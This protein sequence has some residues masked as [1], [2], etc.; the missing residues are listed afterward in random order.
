VSASA[1]AAVPSADE[2]RAWLHDAVLI[3]RFEWAEAVR[4]KLLVVMVLLFVGAGA[5]GAWGF[6]ELLGRIEDNAASLTGAPRVRRPGG[7]LRR[8]RESSSYRDMLRVFTGSEEKATYFASIPPIVVFY[9]WASLVFTPW[10]I[11]FTSAETVATEVA[12]RSIRYT[13]LRTRRSAYAVG[14]ALGQAGILV[15]VTGA[16]ALV[17]YLVAWARLDGFEVGATALGMLSYWPRVVLYNLPF[18]AWAL[19]ASMVTASANLA[20]IASLGGAVVLAIASGLA[21][22]SRLRTG[23]VSEAIGDLVGHLTPFGHHDGLT[24]PPGGALGSDVGVCLALTV[25]YFAAGYA[26]LRQREV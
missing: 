9:G 13:L 8:L 14:K 17:F 20:R 2:R 1:A 19:L 11:L 10:L 18:L 4:S 6:T 12:S 5:L 23:P 25:L 16:S 24:Y 22:S 26:V 15:G 7:T 3:A 21:S